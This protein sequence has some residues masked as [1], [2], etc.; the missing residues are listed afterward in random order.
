MMSYW[1]EPF[2]NR[3]DDVISEV[4]S[5]IRGTVPLWDRIRRNNPGERLNGLLD[6]LGAEE[7]KV[8]AAGANWRAVRDGLER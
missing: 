1:G 8:I 2:L 5:A 7:R 4:N 6:T 3:M